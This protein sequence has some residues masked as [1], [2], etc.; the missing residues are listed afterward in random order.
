MCK[1]AVEPLEKWPDYLTD[2][3]QPY[4][5]WKAQMVFL[6]YTVYTKRGREEEEEEEEEE[7]YISKEKR[8]EGHLARINQK[9]LM[10]LS[11]IDEKSE[12]GIKKK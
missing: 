6:E 4:T 11:L 10:Y 1:K 9:V 12:S 7:K 2:S 5:V 3:L 8:G